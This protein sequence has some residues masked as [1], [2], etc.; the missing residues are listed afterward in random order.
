M[1]FDFGSIIK[2]YIRIRKLIPRVYPFYAIKCMADKNLIS[3]LGSLG[4]GFDCASWDEITSASLALPKPAG[5]FPQKHHPLNSEKIIFSHPFKF[6][7]VSAVF[8]E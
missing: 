4:A 2:Q 8:V 7:N 5:T 6:R 1:V 3:L